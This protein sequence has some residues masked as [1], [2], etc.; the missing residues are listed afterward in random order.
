MYEI[1]KEAS[2][3][4]STVRTGAMQRSSGVRWYVY[5]DGLMM[6]LPRATGAA[7]D[8]GFFTMA[9]AQAYVNRVAGEVK[10]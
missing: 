2:K 1:R 7:G 4:R 3:V 10:A 9:D 8:G 5:R 6:R